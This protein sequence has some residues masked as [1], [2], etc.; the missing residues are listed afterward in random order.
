MT[1]SIL[2]Y[3]QVQNFDR[4]RL[5]AAEEQEETGWKYIHGDVFRPPPQLNLFAA[6]V[7]TGSQILAMAVAIFALALVGV[8]YVRLISMH[9]F[10]W[11][12]LHFVPNVEMT[13]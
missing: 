10:N 11:L 9:G 4:P 13:S 2:T 3:H 5:C 7:G 6:C 8:F 1:G 12:P